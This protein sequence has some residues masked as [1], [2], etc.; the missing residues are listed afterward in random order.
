[1]RVFRLIAPAL[2]L[3]SANV[4]AQSAGSTVLN[5][6]SLPRGYAASAFTAPVAFGAGWGSLGIG[7]VMETSKKDASVSIAAGVGDPSTLIG[8]DVATVLSSLSSSSLGE[9]GLG[10]D[11][12]FAIKL[13]KNLGHYTSV[14]IGASGVG[15][16]GGELMHQNNPAGHYAAISRAVF[17]GRHVLM[18][19]AGAGHNVT[20]KNGN[21]T[22]VFGSAA[23]YLTH[24]FSLIAEYDGL[25]V[26]T[27]VSVS[28]LARWIPLT[29][30]IGAADLA[31]QNNS[32][33]RGM[34]SAGLA[35]H[36]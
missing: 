3:A 8:L 24:W 2:L 6:N 23:F 19:S 14:A 35:Y 18:L 32:K 30:S 27:A 10:D 25:M 15:V 1:M 20:N 9:G 7:S 16:W 11:G 4:C 17:V 33:P 5:T 21:G 12:S 22:D 36:F 13:H 28:P 26:N 34:V 29:I 31:T